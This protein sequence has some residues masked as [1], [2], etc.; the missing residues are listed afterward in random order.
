MGV[1]Q[2]RPAGQVDRDALGAH[3]VDDPR[4]R[5]DRL[6]EDRR[7][8]RRHDHRPRVHGDL[9]P[10]RLLRDAD[11]VHPVLHGLRDQR[12]LQDPEPQVHG[13]RRLHEQDGDRRHARRRPAGGDAPDRGDD[14]PAR[15]R[16]R[17]GSARAAAQELHP[18]RGLPGRGGDRPR[19]RL[20]RLPR[21]A[22][23]AAH[24]RRRRRVPARAGASCASERQLPRHRVL[25]LDGDL[26]PGAVARR[27][28]ER[29]RP[30]GAASTS[31]AIVRV[32]A[33]RRDHRLQRHR[34]AR[35]GPGHVVRADRRRPRRHHARPGRRH[36]RR[37]RHRAVRPRH[38]RLAL[39]G[40]R[41][42]VARQ[43]GDQGGREGQAARGPPARG[44]AGGHRARRTA[45]TRSRARRTRA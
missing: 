28:P 2:A 39:A 42:R 18:G 12:V 7:Q 14:R 9:R 19:L 32:H 31:P 3:D 15:G 26:R 44:G 33:V 22:R 16:A 43:V 27:R 34:A 30:A 20:R 41:R 23:Q 35:P 17:D 38:L 24:A 13:P 40:R 25:H 37:H 6:R 4:P 29:R 21:L 45:S 10:R 1:A 11:A 5:P 36:P 8:A